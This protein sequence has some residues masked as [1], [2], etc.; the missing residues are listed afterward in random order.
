M[1]A[2]SVLRSGTLFLGALLVTVL[3]SG[4]ASADIRDFLFELEMED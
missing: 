2:Q 4:V 3:L 1:F